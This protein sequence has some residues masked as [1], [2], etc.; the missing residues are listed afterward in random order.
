MIE[1]RTKYQ[2][3]GSFTRDSVAHQAAGR[4]SDFAGCGFDE[5][6]LGWVCK[7]EI[8]ARRIK[9][10]LDRVGFATT[11]ANGES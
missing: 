11:L 9:R 5:R 7:S 4:V 1:V 10:S 6:D 8:E 2:W 3:D